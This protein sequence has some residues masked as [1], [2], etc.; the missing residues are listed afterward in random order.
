M[1]NLSLTNLE[2]V[3]GY[4]YSSKYLKNEI[5]CTGVISVEKGDLDKNGKTYESKLTF[6]SVNGNIEG[7]MP[8]ECPLRPSSIHF[9]NLGS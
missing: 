5:P 9:S 4:I 7:D 6:E 1:S 2:G 3:G 8:S